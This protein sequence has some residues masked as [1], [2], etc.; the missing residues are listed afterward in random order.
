MKKISVEGLYGSNKVVIETGQMA[1]QANGSVVVRC[2]KFVVLATATMSKAPKEGIDFFPLTIE[3]AEKMYAGGKIPGGFFKRETRPSTAATLVARLIDRPIRPCFPDHFYRDVQV[4]VTVLSYDETIAAEGLYILAASAAL[5]VSDIPF[6]GPIAAANVSETN[7]SL[8]VNA[9]LDN[10]DLNLDMVVAGT[11]NAVLM[12]ESF[13]QEISESRIIEGI[14][15]GHKAI[16]D[17]V[18]LQQ[19]LVDKVN[20]VKANIEQFSYNQEIVANIENQIGS[21]I[22]EN[23]TK[24]S[25]QQIE[26]FLKRLE[27]QCLEIYSESDQISMAKKVFAKLKKE[28]IRQLMIQK[29][30]RPDGRKPDEVRPISISLDQLPSAHG[31]ALFTRGETQSL[32]V[33]TLGTG[34][35]EQLEEGM[36]ESKKN[37]YYFH[38]N[39]PPYSVGEVGM[40]RTGRRELGH[41]ALA[42]R[43]L[44][45]VLPK[46]EEFPYTLRLVS[47]IFESNGSSS[48]ASVCSGSLALMATGVPIKTGVSGIAMGLLLNQN[49]DYVILSD[50]QGLEDHYGDMDF[51]VAGTKNGITALQL[52]IKV[53]G[54]NQQILEDALHQALKGRH[55][56]LEEMNNVIA[57]PRNT[58]AEHAPK[59]EQITIDP[60]KVGLLIGPKGQ[61]IKK[62]EEETGAVVFVADGN[63]GEVHISGSNSSEVESAK[64]YVLKL[65]RNIEKGDIL[66]AKV[67]KIVPFGAFVELDGSGKEALLHISKIAKE[68]VEKVEDY[69]ALGDEFD[70]EVSDIDK[71]GKIAVSK[72]FSK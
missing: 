18:A 40:L 20:P 59:I 43:A 16:K 22:E 45:A 7:G 41:G 2:G 32:G 44:K 21:Q 42:Q 68:R 4:I 39:F 26:D 71:Q 58:V 12:I 60:E 63:N 8:R 57:S 66:I 65:T 72:I 1:R 38:Y 31:S 17:L 49:G 69:M 52:D 67:T 19:E 64:Q 15:D 47:E 10:E 53:A 54:L 11:S 23:M 14:Q 62:I 6:Q 36:G 48:M 46:H 29:K 34:N 28:K 70:V 51:K 25:K 5:S 24:G 61:T 35:D 55:H 33:V 27:E 50:I 13:A 37:A 9:N 30:V 56:I 3:F